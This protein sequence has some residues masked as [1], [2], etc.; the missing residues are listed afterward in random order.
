MNVLDVES[1]LLHPSYSWGRKPGRVYDFSP[2]RLPT[3]EQS[4]TRPRAARKKKNKLY[5]KKAGPVSPI[6]VD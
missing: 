6:T 4:V 3:V 5:S 2:I 1:S